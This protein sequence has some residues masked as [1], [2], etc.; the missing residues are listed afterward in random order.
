LTFRLVINE[1]ANGDQWKED[2][3]VINAY[4]FGTIY[5]L[6]PYRC[7]ECY[8]NSPLCEGQVQSPE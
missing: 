1:I 2:H 4:A 5:M 8:G 7:R 6:S 3:V